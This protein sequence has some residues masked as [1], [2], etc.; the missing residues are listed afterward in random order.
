M[1]FVPQQWKEVYPWGLVPSPFIS[2]N[3]RIALKVR[4]HYDDNI[5]DKGYLSSC[6]YNVLYEEFYS[7]MQHYVLHVL[8]CVL[9]YVDRKQ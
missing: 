9:Q 8:K 5:T 6:A 7:N 2:N 3:L 4:Q 1:S